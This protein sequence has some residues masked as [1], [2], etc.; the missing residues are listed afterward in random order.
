MP[1]YEF[2]PE[3]EALIRHP[4]EI[5]RA[6]PGLEWIAGIGAE[7]E[8]TFR[9]GWV[10]RIGQRAGLSGRIENQVASG[11]GHD[12]SADGPGK[13]VFRKPDAVIDHRA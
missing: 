10:V 8:L 11:I 5:G 7:G 9:L 4:V 3:E 2:Y 13:F 6:I 1:V 12:A